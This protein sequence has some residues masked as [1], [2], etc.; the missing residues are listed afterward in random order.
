MALFVLIYNLFLC[1]R[2]F[3]ADIAMTTLS[4]CRVLVMPFTV[5]IQMKRCNNSLSEI[6]SENSLSW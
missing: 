3:L 5:R 4:K 6:L 1:D 2:E